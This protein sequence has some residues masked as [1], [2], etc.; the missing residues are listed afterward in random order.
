MTRFWLIADWLVVGLMLFDVAAQLTALLTY[1]GDTSPW[2]LTLNSG[3]LV[4][5]MVMMANIPVPRPPR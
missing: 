5:V 1:P 2:Y 4:M 3:L